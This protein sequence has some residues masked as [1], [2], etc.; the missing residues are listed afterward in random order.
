M[1]RLVIGVPRD[2]A[3]V[4]CHDLHGTA[5]FR[6]RTRSQTCTPNISS[7]RAMPQNSARM[8]SAVLHGNVRCCAIRMLL[9]GLYP[10]MAAVA[11][12]AGQARTQPAARTRDMR[13]SLTVRATMSAINAAGHCVLMPS[14]APAADVTRGLRCSIRARNS[15]T[16][17]FDKSWKPQGNEEQPQYMSGVHRPHQAVHPLRSKAP[18]RQ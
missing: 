5:G 13:L 15:R 8:A 10:L 7:V 14:C 11:T 18:M 12:K 6:V 3:A 9:E 16:R 2:A 4:K 1:N 17:G